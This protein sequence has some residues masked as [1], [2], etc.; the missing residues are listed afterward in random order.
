MIPKSTLILIEYI[1]GAGK[2]LSTKESG[3]I[4]FCVIQAQ[5]NRLLTEKQAKWLQ[6]IYGR[7]TQ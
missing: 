3:F 4:S 7:V 2:K 1:R 6:D 5:A